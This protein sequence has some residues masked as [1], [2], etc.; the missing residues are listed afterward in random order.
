MSGGT[1][2]AASGE[3]TLWLDGGIHLK[4]QEPSGDPIEMSED[5]AVELANLLLKLVEDAKAHG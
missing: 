5:E 2:S 1:Y 3:I 4:V